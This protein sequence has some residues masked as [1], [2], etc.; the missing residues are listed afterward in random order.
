MPR[1]VT[2]QDSLAIL[3][4]KMLAKDG[5]MMKTLMPLEV[6]EGR[7]VGLSEWRDLKPGEGVGSVEPWGPAGGGRWAHS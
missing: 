1:F 3:V 5:G 2:M 6:T 7:R 4:R